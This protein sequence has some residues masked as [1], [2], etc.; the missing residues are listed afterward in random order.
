MEISWPFHLF[1]CCLVTDA[2]GAY[3]ITSAERAKDTKKKPVWVLGAAESHDH[4]MTSQM[5]DLTRT[6]AK[7]TGPAAM[8]RAGVPTTT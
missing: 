7:N 3:V 4:N 1:D 2:G 8:R 6:V 5:P